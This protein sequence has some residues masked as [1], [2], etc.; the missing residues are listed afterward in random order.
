MKW[1]PYLLKMRFRNPDHAFGLWLPLFLIWPV[2]LAFL[3]AIFIILLPFAL[4]TLIFTWRSNWFYCL[5]LSVPAVYRLFSQLPGLVVDVGG[6]QGQVY[7]E[8][9]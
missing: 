6:K 3:L 8:F 2:V 4:L 1:P 5:L 7:V 9:I